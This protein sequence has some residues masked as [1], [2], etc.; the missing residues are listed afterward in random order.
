MGAQGCAGI[1]DFVPLF[2]G[3]VDGRA[4]GAPGLEASRPRG[5][6]VRPVRPARRLSLALA[7]PIPA[8]GGARGR[9]GPI[10]AAGGARGR[11]G[12]IPAAGG[13][14]VQRGRRGRRVPR[15]QQGG[16]RGSRGPCV[17]RGEQPGAGRSWGGF[18]RPPSRRSNRRPAV[19]A[20]GSGQGLVQPAPCP[21]GIGLAG[22]KR[23]TGARSPRRL[24]CVPRAW[25]TSLEKQVRQTPTCPFGSRD[26]A[27]QALVG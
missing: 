18:G 19:P 12:P 17:L 24:H 25:G 10:P 16:L 1:L 23:G 11:R 21:R 20:R 26:P 13:A 8:A 15:P 4:V 2:R 9:R 22:G 14:R 5:V 6:W 27:R 7:G 3:H